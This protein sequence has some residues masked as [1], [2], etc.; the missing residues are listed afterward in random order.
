MRAVLAPE[1]DAL[2]ERV[3]KCAFTV[4]RALGHGFLEAVY[5]NALAIELEQVGIEHQK[6]RA[7]PVFYRGERVGNYI[8]DLVVGNVIIV[9]LKVVEALSAPHSAQ[10]HN[11]LKAS[12]FPV[13]LLFNFGKPRIDVRRVLL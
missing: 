4:T 11:Y 7:F 10:L 3:I 2:T 1:L 6:E 8:A 12:Q 13:G 9:E 5:K